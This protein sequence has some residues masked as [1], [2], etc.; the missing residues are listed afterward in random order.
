MNK[1][2][3]ID[4]DKKYSVNDIKSVSIV[5]TKYVTGD[6]EPFIKVSAGK[7]IRRLFRKSIIFNEDGYKLDSFCNGR[8]GAWYNKYYLSVKDLVEAIKMHWGEL[9]GGG[10]YAH[11]P[12]AEYT[13]GF[14]ITS[15]KECIAY[16]EQKNCLMIK[17]HV[18]I[19][20]DENETESFSWLGHRR[21]KMVVKVFETDADAEN[22]YNSLQ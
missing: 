4:G 19:Y 21:P 5:K 6:V 17:P 14:Y 18:N 2:F 15:S 16:N 9:S 10:Y 12:V 20:F 3:I 11:L 7:K 1:N 22:Y 8:Y 13:A